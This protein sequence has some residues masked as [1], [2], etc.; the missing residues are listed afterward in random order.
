[1]RRELGMRYLEAIYERYHKAS[2]GSKGRI[3]DEFCKVCGYNH[4]YAIWKLNRM[5]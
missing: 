1:M 4:K 5:P 3:L 2:K